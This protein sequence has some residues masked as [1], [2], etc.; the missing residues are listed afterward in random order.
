MPFKK[1]A[2]SATKFVKKR[3]VEPYTSLKKNR[4]YNNRM[5]L[6]KEVAEI[7]KMV[8][9]E[10]KN[11]DFV[12]TTTITLGQF[13][14]PGVS[15]RQVIDITP[16]IPQG[17]TEDDR[18]GDSLKVCSW[19]YTLQVSA[20]TGMLQDVNY[21]FYI[22]RQPVNP[23]SLADVS[24][25][26]LEPNTFS[27]VVDYN[28]N[29]NYQH[30]KDYRIM[31]VIQGKIKPKDDL[32]STSVNVNN[33]VCARKQEFHLRYVKGT[34]T[35]LQNPIVVVAV[36]SDGDRNTPNHC[37]FQHAMKVYFYDN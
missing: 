10:K 36:A 28:S 37:T 20:V 14:N 29:R 17:L 6:Y 1:Y 22:L 4:G 11:A 21:K 35:L 23:S 3:V 34:T 24:T 33:H 26:F 5:R 30:Y 18:S 2:K 31:G 15:G 9:A 7:K 16:I 32:A 27:S 13:N 25:Q 19:C 12:S 8:N